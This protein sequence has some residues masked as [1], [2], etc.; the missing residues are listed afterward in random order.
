[1]STS[2]LMHN[3]NVSSQIRLILK[4]L[5]AEMTGNLWHIPMNESY[6]VVK[7]IFGREFLRTIGAGMLSYAF[8]YPIDMATQMGFELELLRALTAF[9]RTFIC[10]LQL[11]V[12][13]Q[14][15]ATGEP[16]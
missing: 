4:L 15:I 6:M 16:C 7:V 11:G 3:T 12:S 14:C 2:S 8:V 5:L 1:M 9:K 13:K 10:M